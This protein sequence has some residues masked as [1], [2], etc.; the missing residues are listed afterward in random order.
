MFV[1]DK[2][3]T[4]NTIYNLNSEHVR[5]EYLP[6]DVPSLEPGNMDIAAN[7]GFGSMPLGFMYEPLA[8][9]GDSKKAQVKTYIQLVVDRPNA[10]GKRVNVS[11]S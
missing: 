4:A 8:K 5:V 2:D 3:A 7:D 9:T 6:P 10:C 11:E 1:R